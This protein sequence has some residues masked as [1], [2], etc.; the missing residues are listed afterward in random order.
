MSPRTI[1][2][3]IELDF[4]QHCQLQCG[5]YAQTHEPHDNTM[6]HRTVG[7]IGLRPTGNAQGG[8]FYLSL[9]TGRRLNRTHCTPLPMPDEVIDRMHR[10]ARRAPEGLTFGDRDNNEIAP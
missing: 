7:A 3:G 10:L 1:I 8:Y 4:N 2:T 6:V 9:K 5:E